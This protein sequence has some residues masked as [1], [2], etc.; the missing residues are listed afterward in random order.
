MVHR[1]F[2]FIW[3]PEKTQRN[4]E[5]TIKITPPV[6]RRNASPPPPALCVGTRTPHFPDLAETSVFQ[7]RNRKATRQRSLESTGGSCTW[8]RT[9]KVSKR[10]GGRAGTNK[11]DVKDKGGKTALHFWGTFFLYKILLCSGRGSLPPIL[12]TPLYAS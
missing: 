6:V 11:T 7:G 3:Q 5:S 4:L 2:V 1:A 9:V 10:R 8:R 12:I